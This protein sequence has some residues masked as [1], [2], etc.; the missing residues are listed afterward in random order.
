MKVL[1]H[2]P[3]NIVLSEIFGESTP[4]QIPVWYFSVQVLL[5]AGNSAFCVTNQNAIFLSF[6]HP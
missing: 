5:A 1:L 6:Q 2:L 4:L 3:F